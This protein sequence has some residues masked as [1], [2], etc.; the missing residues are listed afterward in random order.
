VRQIAAF[1]TLAR[2]KRARV[3]GMQREGDGLAE[4]RERFAEMQ[5]SVR[6]SARAAAISGILETKPTA[7]IEP[8]TC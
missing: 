6:G 8:A 3:F 4:E 2:E 5:G 1:E 7:G